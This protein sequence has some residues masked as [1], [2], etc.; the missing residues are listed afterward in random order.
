MDPFREANTLVLSCNVLEPTTGKGYERD[1]R[2]IAN[3]A[4]SYLKSTGIG[5]AAFFGPEPEF[6][7]FDGVQWI[8]SLVRA[9]SA[10]LLKK[11]RGRRVS[12][13]RAA[14]SVTAIA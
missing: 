8:I 6:F 4:E 13:W 12:T 9:S 1:P 10:L 14:T 2:S 5:D 7:I 11:R 3:R